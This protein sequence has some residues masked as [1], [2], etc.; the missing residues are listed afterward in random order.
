MSDQYTSQSKS[1]DFKASLVDNSFKREHMGTDYAENGASIG[2]TTDEGGYGGDPFSRENQAPQQK[3]QFGQNRSLDNSAPYQQQDGKEEDDQDRYA[4]EG[5]IP[6]KLAIS[7]LI[8]QH[9]RYLADRALRSPHPA[10]QATGAQAASSGVGVR[11]QFTQ[12]PQDGSNIG[13]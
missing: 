2:D 6:R 10:N 3:G 7:V 5:I 8:A 11:S 12:I 1:G 9:L 13:A 4:G